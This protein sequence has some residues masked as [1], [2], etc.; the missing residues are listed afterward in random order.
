MSLKTKSMIQR[1]KREKLRSL[2]ARLAL[3]IASKENEA[4][5]KQ[6]VLARKKY[7]A[8]KLM[9]IKKYTPKALIAAR[10]LLKQTK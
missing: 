2:V 8:T 1:T 7:L 6:Y 4:G 10:E 9:L 3:T 5:Y